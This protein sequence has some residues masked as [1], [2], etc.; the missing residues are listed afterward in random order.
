M[1][2]SCLA[3]AGVWSDRHN[4][5][6]TDAQSELVMQS[7]TRHSDAPEMQ[8]TLIHVRLSHPL[9]LSSRNRVKPADKEASVGIIAT[10]TALQRCQA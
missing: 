10:R 9:R 7:I 6:S 3:H 1:R 8:R 4:A 5:S 2:R